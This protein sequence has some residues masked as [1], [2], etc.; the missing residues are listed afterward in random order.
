MGLQQNRGQLVFEAHAGDL[1]N[2]VNPLGKLGAGFSDIPGT[3]GGLRRLANQFFM[4]IRDIS[5][6]IPETGG[7]THP[8]DP[9]TRYVTTRTIGRDSILVEAFHR[10]NRKGGF[11]VD[12]G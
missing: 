12:Y 11:P 7:N 3:T 6:D 8:A 2:R 1:A 9:F 4:K 5:G 10:D